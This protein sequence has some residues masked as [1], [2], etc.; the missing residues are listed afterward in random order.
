MRAP[1]AQRCPEDSS[2]YALAVRAV[3]FDLVDPAFPARLLD[4]PEPN[5]PGEAWARVAVTAGGICGSDLHL[6]GHNMVSSPALISIGTFPFVLGHE[7][8]GRVVEAGPGCPVPVGTRVAVDPCIPCLAQA[9]TPRA[10]TAH[11]GGRRRAPTSTAT[12]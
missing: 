7:I 12:S 3:Q 10:P 11:G 4:L 2:A 6:F 9:S 8:G 1:P 5:L